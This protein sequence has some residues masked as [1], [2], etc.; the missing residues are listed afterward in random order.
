MKRPV[1]PSSGCRLGFRTARRC[2]VE[3]KCRVRSCAVQRLVLLMLRSC[4]FMTQTV[5]TVR[6]ACKVK[7]CANHTAKEKV[8]S[9]PG[10]C[11]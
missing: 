3:A 2:Q 6:I 1:A 7:L 10:N 9:G 4:D 11:F 8:W 5:V